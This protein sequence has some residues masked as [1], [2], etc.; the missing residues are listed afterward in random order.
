MRKRASYSPPRFKDAKDTRFAALVR[1]ANKGRPAA[2]NILGM[3]FDG[4]V[5]GRRGA[6]EGPSA[7]RQSLSSFS[8]YN[9]ELGVDLLATK[10]FDLGNV[11]LD[12]D[13]RGAHRQIE[14][15]VGAEL[16]GDSLLLVLGGDNSVSLPSLRAYAKKFGRIGLVVVD[17]HLDLR[18]EIEGRPTSGSSYG[19]AVRTVKGL[20]PKRVAEIGMHGFLN[21]RSYAEEAEK[22]GLAV[23]TATDVRQRGAIATARE[24]FAIASEGSEAVYFSTDLDAV[25]LAYVSG[26][27]APSAGGISATELFDIA[28]YLGGRDK[29]KCADL[30]ELAP[31]LDPTGRSQV[32]A[33][34]ALV[35]LV[36][37]FSSRQ[38]S[39]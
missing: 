12:D 21:S 17:S 26:V 6:A 23:Y 32:T 4:A 30:V 19:L 39:A 22:L 18:G 33:A 37:G 38:L 29:V 36:A 31:S 27:S 24:A 10:V 9:K 2:V 3:P 7:I 1:Q 28:Y 15:E 35:Y 25:D 8:N 13:V 34:T 5:L 11:V 20:D 14:R 16:R